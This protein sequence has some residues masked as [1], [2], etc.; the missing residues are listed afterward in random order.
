VVVVEHAVLL[1][2]LRREILLHG[3]RG[4]QMKHAIPAILVGEDIP[5]ALKAVLNH[6]ATIAAILYSVTQVFLGVACAVDVV[7]L[8]GDPSG[9]RVAEALD[10]ILANVISA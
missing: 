4:P 8:E 5:F 7:F 10:G 9:A 3:L 1:L 6:C 2:L